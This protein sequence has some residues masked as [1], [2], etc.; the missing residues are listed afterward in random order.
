[1]RTTLLGI[2]FGVTALLSAAPAS[3]DDETFL[4]ALEM[5]GIAADDPA[6]AVAMG[7]SVCASFD[8][9]QTVPVIVDRL[10]TQHGLSVDQAGLVTGFSVAEYC[11]HHE[12]ALGG[13]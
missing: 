1:M 3:A 13:P 6:A 7:R 12:G 11:D 8:N 5:V 10:S 4:G 2:L 9:G